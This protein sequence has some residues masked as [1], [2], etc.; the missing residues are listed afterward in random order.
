MTPSLQPVKPERSWELRG[1][2]H[3]WALNY[4]TVGG[5]VV[6]NLRTWTACTT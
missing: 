1:S 4:E 5:L 6:P 3:A 2:R